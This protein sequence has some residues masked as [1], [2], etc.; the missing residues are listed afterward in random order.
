MTRVRSRD[1]SIGTVAEKPTGGRLVLVDEAERI[2]ALPSERD[3]GAVVPANPTI[4]VP[5][6]YPLTTR[7]THTLKCAGQIA[8]KF[9]AAELLV[10]HVN[11]DH[12]SHSATAAEIYEAVAPV[13]QNHPVSVSVCRSFLIEEAIL[14]EAQASHADIIVLGK[15][16]KPAWRRVLSRLVGADLEIRQL[17]CDQTDA[18]IRVVG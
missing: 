8:D 16:R 13:V 7:S 1:Y 3:A 18:E 4:L 11:L 15:N 10:V 2:T 9:G 14:E 17:L 12:H 6:R 5:I